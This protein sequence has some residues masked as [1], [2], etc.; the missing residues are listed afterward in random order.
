MA[1]NRYSLKKEKKD[2]RHQINIYRKKD[3]E[4]NNGTY[5]LTINTTMA[6]YNY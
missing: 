6:M 3:T 4:K 2:T 5:I 1:S